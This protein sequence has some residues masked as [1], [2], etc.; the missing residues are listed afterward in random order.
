[1]DLETCCGTP[2]LENGNRVKVLVDSERCQGH[3]RCITFLPEVLETDD[4]GYSHVKGAGEVPP[5]LEDRA[6]RAV[7]NCPE[8]AITTVDE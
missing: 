2:N 6:R 5:E 1:V 4:L 8:Q 3:A 7:A